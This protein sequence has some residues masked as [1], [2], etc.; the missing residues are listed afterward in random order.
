MA[1]ELAEKQAEQQRIEQQRAQEAMAKEEQARR[2]AGELAVKRE[3]D[4]A[5]TEQKMHQ[6]EQ[7]EQQVNLWQVYFRTCSIAL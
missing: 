6:L 1:R 2:L 3:H 7:A 5:F 4:R